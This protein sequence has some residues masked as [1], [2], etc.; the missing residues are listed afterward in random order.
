L[1]G[2]SLL[3][4][5]LESND[6]EV[7]KGFEDGGEH[8]VPLLSVRLV[9]SCSFRSNLVISFPRIKNH[10]TPSV[11][12]PDRPATP[13]HAPVRGV[14]SGDAKNVDTGQPNRP[15]VVL[16]AIFCHDVR[17]QVRERR[18]CPRRFS[19]LDGITCRPQKLE[20]LVL[21]L[22]RVNPTWTVD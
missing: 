17:A 8:R 6:L 4:V 10:S 12:D 18:S 5:V 11:A 2:Q 13:R 3:C 19:F 20:R 7:R 1:T 21:P 9:Q 16:K 22:I 15:H 14:L